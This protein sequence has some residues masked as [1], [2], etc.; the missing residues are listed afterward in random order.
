MKVTIWDLD[1]YYASKKQ[2]CNNPDVM[3]I[4]SY[5]KQKGDQVNFVVKEDDIYRPYDLYY[6]IK[7][8]QKTPLPPI[9]FFVNHRVRW[10]G[11]AFKLRINWKMPNEMLMCRPDYLLYPELNTKFERS[12]HIRL[13][14]NEGQLLP[15]SQDWSNTF[16]NKFAIVT[17]EHLWDADTGVLISA[18]QKLQ[19]LKNISFFHPICIQKILSDEK[20]KEE[21]L[22]LHFIR[23]SSLDWTLITMSE[24][25]AAWELLEDLK[26]RNSGLKLGGITIDYMTTNKTHWDS[27]EVALEDFKCIRAVI[28]RAKD[29][30]FQLNIKMPSTRMETP[31]FFLFEELANWTKNYLHKSWLEYITD[32]FGNINNIYDM[33][34]YW[35]SP[36]LWSE[37]FKNMLQQ[38]WHDREFL[39]NQWKGKKIAEMSIAWKI[40][41]KELTYGI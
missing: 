11:K 6:L 34:E 5:H 18:L 14:G 32:R 31:Y 37:L 12:E 29:E 28:K 23:G 26:K 10:W 9:D 19:D 21:F 3:K 7:E 40:W 17:D 30:G 41:E 1:Y 36:R 27:K 4:S 8:K 39:L 38:T 35:N 15:L 25:D 13:L 33:Y 24:F 20:V 16:K 2:N 22:K